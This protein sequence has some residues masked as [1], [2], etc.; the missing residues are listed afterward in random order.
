MVPHAVGYLMNPLLLHIHTYVLAVAF[1]IKRCCHGW[2]GERSAYTADR[3]VR[4]GIDTCMGRKVFGTEL[5]PTYYI[6]GDRT[7]AIVPPI[8][9]TRQ[10]KRAGKS[11]A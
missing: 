2:H 1:A 11:I 9:T 7:A 4:T 3:G 8:F 6:V 5:V 10:P